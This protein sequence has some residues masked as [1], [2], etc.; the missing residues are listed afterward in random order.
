M[1]NVFALLC[2]LVS[3]SAMAFPAPSYYCQKGN[4]AFT[5]KLLPG[6]QVGYYQEVK[7][8]NGPIKGYFAW[9]GSTTPTVLQCKKDY[10][11]YVGSI[12]AQAIT[13][14]V[15]IP[16]VIK[17]WSVQVPRG[18][19][20]GTLNKGKVTSNVAFTKD[21]VYTCNLNE[22]LAAPTGHR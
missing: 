15:A 8:T 4:D 2:S 17:H 16:K 10:S 5:L 7:T 20:N 11:C 21:V 9:E 12:A 1:K 14:G 3:V 13:P 22:V 18:F 6:N 19:L